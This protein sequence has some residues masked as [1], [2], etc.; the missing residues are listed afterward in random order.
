MI[1]PLNITFW[2]SN[3]SSL[4][5]HFLLLSFLTNRFSPLS[6]NAT[7]FI[8]FS[9]Q[10]EKKTSTTQIYL[11]SYYYYFV[12]SCYLFEHD[13]KKHKIIYVQNVALNLRQFYAHR[14]KFSKFYFSS[15]K[16]TGKGRIDIF[17]VSTA[18]GKRFFA[19]TT[20]LDCRREWNA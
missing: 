6:F 15:N 17:K 2:Q 9:W 4:A 8:N 16:H 12:I 14:K 20:R 10:N 19:S 7:R 18:L 5:R 3:C 1:L 11:V 13:F